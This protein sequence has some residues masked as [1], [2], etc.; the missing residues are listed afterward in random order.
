M[1]FTY[2]KKVNVIS[3]YGCEEARSSPVLVLQ[4]SL[5]M[6]V[7]NG[8]QSAVMHQPFNWQNPA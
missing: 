1:A 8:Q 3:F 6:I 4:L 2:L 5:D 7:A